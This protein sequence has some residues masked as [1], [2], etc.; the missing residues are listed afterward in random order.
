MA[1]QWFEVDDAKT[2][3]GLKLVLTKRVPN[4]WAEGAKALFEVKRIP[5]IRVSQR[6]ATPNAE[7][8]AWTGQTSAPVAVLDNE[9]PRT[10]WSEIVLLAE[11]LQPTPRLI[12]ADPTDRAMMFGYLH[13]LCGEMGFGWCRRLHFTHGVLSESSSPLGPVAQYIAGR[14]GYQSADH[15]V[16]AKRIPELLNLFATR[17]HHQ[18]E[19]GKHFFI[20]DALTALDLYW[21]TFAALL[22]PLPPD[23][24]DMH[25]IGRA[26][27]TLVDPTL[28]RCVDPI[29]LEHR[30]RIYRKYLT[31][32]IELA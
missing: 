31:L 27:Y 32:P 26:L 17:L 25:E 22:Q 21:A 5:Y 11:R 29:L 28:L 18:Y 10:H 24:C 19:Q 1:V 4:P 16:I 9:K 6:V 13:E 15:A 8:Q 7:L 3:P 14:Y 30:D 12:P 23:L 20:G 2:M